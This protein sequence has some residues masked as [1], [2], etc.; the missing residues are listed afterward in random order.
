[1]VEPRIRV[2]PVLISIETDGVAMANGS[3][4][5]MACLF[6]YA[7]ACE[8]QLQQYFAFDPLVQRHQSDWSY[9]LELARQQPPAIWVISCYVWNVRE[10]LDLARQIKEASPASLIL[11]G[12]PHIPAYEM[13]N[14]QFFEEHPWIDVTV[15]GEGEM[16][17]SE[18]LCAIAQADGNFDTDLSAVNGVAFRQSDGSI[19]K[20]AERPK[21]RD[22]SHFPSPYLSGELDDASFDHQDVLVL[23]TNRG[24]PFGCTFCDWGAATLQKFSLFDMERLRLEIEVIAQ[25]KPESIY[26]ADSNFGAFERDIEIAQ[27][28]ADAKKKYG[29]PKRFGSSFAKNAS[30]RLAEIIRILHAANLQNVGLISMQSTD[31]DT[32]SAIRRSNI[33]N[34]KYEQLI[35]IFK[36]E[37]MSLSSEL[38]IGL[39]GQTLES[40][41]RDLQFFIDRKLMT[42]AYN[43]QVMPN[44][45]MNEPSYRE[46]YKI[47]TDSNGYVIS[48]STF[49]DVEQIF[50]IKRFLAFQL[51]HVLGVLRYFLYFL[52]LEHRIKA[53]DFVTDLLVLLEQPEGE[54][55]FPLAARV[56]RELLVMKHEWSPCLIWET[57][58]S[59]FLFNGLDQFYGEMREFAES[60]YGVMMAPSVVETLF[61]AQRSVMPVL[62]KE[63]PF[64]VTFPHDIVGWFEQIKALRVA[65]HCPVGFR[66]LADWPAGGIDVRARKKR[67]IQSLSLSHFN[68]FTG[69]GWELHSPLR[70]HG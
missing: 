50:M 39:P 9:Y 42:I 22:L 46:K 55:A 4:L 37:G 34:E 16:T 40:Q 5:P 33:R 52:Q 1:M 44:A 12:G 31:E 25:K 2:V 27:L 58:E 15:R 64:S 6:S 43:V 67:T 66:P 54:V 41:K 3:G 26:V 10:L 59:E 45:P 19:V 35:D 29:Y 56:N 28:I 62:G 11:A 68:R 21:S 36:R 65:D 18:I 60:R 61:V 57:E 38:L 53:M 23:E 8:L 24:C 69:G 17:F 7:K 32:L 47:K 14:L 63:L 51:F 13:D 48:T 30:A 49:T 20:T 70:L